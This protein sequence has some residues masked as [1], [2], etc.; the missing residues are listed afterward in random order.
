MI[1]SLIKSLRI[2]LF[3]FLMTSTYRKSFLLSSFL[4]AFP[5]PLHED[6]S[7]R[8]LPPDLVKAHDKLQA[9]RKL[10]LILR[11]KATNEVP[12]AADD[13][14]EIFMKREKDRR[15]TWSDPKSFLSVDHTARSIV[16]PTKGSRRQTVAIE[17]FR[18]SIPQDSLTH[19][20]QQVIDPIDYSIDDSIGNPSG[21]QVFD[22]FLYP[23]SEVS[24][25]V[26]YY[27]AV[28]VDFSG[29]S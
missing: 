22:I 17:D 15:G 14:V 21:S 4:K 13:M 3:S 1:I 19:S 7:T 24:P 8:S 9:K 18:L 20:V 11:S 28:V 27:T 23:S 29:C 16:F 2:V 10:A 25:S 12:I 5:S 26:S 6:L